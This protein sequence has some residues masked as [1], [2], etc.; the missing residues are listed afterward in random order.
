[1]APARGA[2]TGSLWPTNGIR[3]M[4]SGLPDLLW[5]CLRASA[6]R[7]GTAFILWDLFVWRT[8]Y[9]T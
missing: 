6:P 5:R 7:L 4:S 2:Y 1:M 8:L 9:A 3:P